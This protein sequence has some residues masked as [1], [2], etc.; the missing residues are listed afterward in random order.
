MKNSS[1]LEV[2]KG[3]ETP[4]IQLERARA[5]DKEGLVQLMDAKYLSSTANQSATDLITSLPL[6][7]YT[8]I[9]ACILSAA[10]AR[11]EL[12]SR[13]WPV[14]SPVLML[15]CQQCDGPA[16]RLAG[17]EGQSDEPYS[18][19]ALVDFLSISFALTVSDL[20]NKL[21]RFAIDSGEQEIQRSAV[22]GLSAL[23]GRYL[24]SAN[25]NTLTTVSVALLHLCIS[26]DQIDTAYT[27]VTRHAP[28]AINLQLFKVTYLDNLLWHYY[29]GLVHTHKHDLANGMESFERVRFCCRLTI[30]I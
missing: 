20:A 11:S 29:A 27:F 17:Q 9:W 13:E 14:I 24:D 4:H 21:V 26:C 23:L 12:T 3:W 15:F 1:S 18:T 28:T 6:D 25:H 2:I 7:R 22:T 19:Q 5:L 30:A 16:A 8:V 10:M